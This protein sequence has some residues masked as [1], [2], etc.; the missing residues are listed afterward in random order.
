MDTLVIVSIVISAFLHAYWNLLLKSSEQPKLFIALSKI[1]EAGVFLLPF[2]Y[3]QQHYALQLDQLYIV[4]IAALLVFVSYYALALTYQHLDISIG[5]PISRSSTLFLPLLAWFFLNEQLAAVGI[6]AI[7]L[8]TAGIVLLSITGSKSAANGAV[9]LSV[10]G[11]L[12]ALLVA[13][14]SALQTLWS[15]V[16]IAEI[17]PFI[18]FYSYTLLVA[19]GYMLVIFG[20]YKINHVRQQ[21]S[22]SWPAMLLVGILNTASYGLFLYALANANTAYVGAL[23]QLSLVFALMLG[24]WLLKELLTTQKIAGTI[25]VII[26]SLL[27]TLAA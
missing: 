24:V 18:F 11:V 27:L 19:I 14:I 16:A 3:F 17:H 9:T 4:V 26:G 12:I 8:I 10:K 25:V 6:G 1:M 23:R 15:K 22:R 5:Y 13:L 20:K 21:L 2:C 7:V